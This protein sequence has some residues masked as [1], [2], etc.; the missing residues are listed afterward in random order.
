MAGTTRVELEEVATEE[1]GQIDEDKQQVDE[2][3]S[4]NFIKVR[5]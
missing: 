1:L 3:H 2:T 5:P 4:M